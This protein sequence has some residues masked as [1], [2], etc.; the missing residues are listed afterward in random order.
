MSLF[1]MQ[2]IVQVLESSAAVV[3]RFASA[4][5]KSLWQSHLTQAAYS[6]SVSY[7]WCR[8]EQDVHL[9]PDPGSQMPMRVLSANKTV[10]A[11]CTSSGEDRNRPVAES[12]RVCPW[13]LSPSAC[14]WAPASLALTHAVRTC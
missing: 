4:E 11:G 9:A 6:A 12:P 14:S 8:I 13:D 7:K 2:H 3:L 5:D 1:I 10:V